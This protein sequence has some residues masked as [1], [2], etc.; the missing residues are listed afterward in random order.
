MAKRRLSVMLMGAGGNMRHAHVPRLLADGA[1]DIV[2]VA[3]PLEANARQ[4]LERIARDGPPKREAAYFADW[5]AMLKSGEAAGADAVL[6]ST[7]HDVHYAQASASLEQGLHTLVEKPLVVEAHHAKR[8]LALAEE[9]ERALV[10]AYQR[11][12]LPHFVYARELVRK[13]TL[14]EIKG[15]SA[16]VTQN[17]LGIGGW[18]LDPV[19]SGGGMFMDTGSHLVAA[20]LWVSGLQPLAVSGVFDNGGRTVDVNGAATVQFAGG[21]VGSIATTGSAA[22]HDERLAIAGSRGSLVLHLHNW[23]VRS[24]L[25]ND[26]PAALPKRIEAA[27]PDSAFLRWIRNGLKGF[28]MPDYALRVAQLTQAAYRSAREGKPAKV[29]GVR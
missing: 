15:V 12:W 16:Y 5:R 9:R 20:L 24:M 22:R 18:R 3:D 21:A 23:Q 6:I 17:W 29:S 13:G 11:H 1:T 25:L 10:V 8:L 2:A 4:L 26:E 19:A 14:G 27:T 28:E 7:P